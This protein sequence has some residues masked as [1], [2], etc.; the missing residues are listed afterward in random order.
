MVH[1]DDTGRRVEFTISGIERRTR[2]R[3]PLKLPTPEV[4]DEIKRMGK[5]RG[6]N[7]ERIFA[8]FRRK[9]H[10]ISRETITYILEQDEARQ[11][12]GPG[13]KD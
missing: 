6:V 8:Y 2:T 9:R 4:Q 5:Q 1:D 13:H 11:K 12:R 3:R 7:I 10:D